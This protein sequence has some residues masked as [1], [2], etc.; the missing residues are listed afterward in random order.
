MGIAYI[1]L[2]IFGKI[3]GG[4]L[5]AKFCQ[6]S[7][8]TQ[9]WVGTAMLPQAGVAVGMALAAS[10]AFPQYRQILLPLVIGSTIF[11]ELIGPILTR[12]ALMQVQ[13]TDR[14]SEV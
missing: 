8:S 1:L 3:L 12:H 11:F 7:R 14:D 6:A 2:R 13:N 10:M 9:R 5:G 4:L